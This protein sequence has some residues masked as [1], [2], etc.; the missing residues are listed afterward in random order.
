MRSIMAAQFVKNVTIVERAEEGLVA[1]ATLS[2]AVL[3]NFT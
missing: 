1:S 3:I 2:E